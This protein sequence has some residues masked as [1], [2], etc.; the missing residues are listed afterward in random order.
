M[1]RPRGPE[2]C[3]RKPTKKD[4]KKEK[5]ENVPSGA[6]N[7]T[8]ANSQKKQKRQI[9]CLRAAPEINEG[10]TFHFQNHGRHKKKEKRK[11]KDVS[12]SVWRRIC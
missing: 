10:A 1:Q 11:K 3:I 5:T 7:R 9:S 6:W 8:S 12:R 2:T 4:K